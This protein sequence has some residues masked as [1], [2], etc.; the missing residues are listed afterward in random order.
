M[1]IM[2]L[3]GGP[4]LSAPSSDTQS[5]GNASSSQ[6]QSSSENFF[7]KILTAIQGGGSSEG[8]ATSSSDLALPASKS[9]DKNG[10]TDPNQLLSAMIMM[11]I[12][13][14]LH[15]NLADANCGKPDCGQGSSSMEASISVQTA[16]ISMDQTIHQ[17]D[18]SDLQIHREIQAVAVSIEMS[19]SSSNSASA[20][21]QVHDGMN[22]I[23][24]TLDDLM[25]KAE[26]E[27]EKNFASILDSHG[28]NSPLS[29]PA[30]ANTND[31]NLMRVGNLSTSSRS[32]SIEQTRSW[33]S[34]SNGTAIAVPGSQG[35]FT[36]PN[37]DASSSKESASTP[38]TE[39]TAV[40]GATEPK[41]APTETKLG[42]LGQ[43]RTD[44][45]P[46]LQMSNAVGMPKGLSEWFSTFSNS[47]QASIPE[48]NSASAMMPTNLMSN[49]GSVPNSDASLDTGEI[50]KATGKTDSPS[51]PVPESDKLNDGQG[52]NQA[53]MATSPR[54]ESFLESSSSVGRSEN[55]ASI[56]PQPELQ[57]TMVTHARI[58][59]SQGRSE[60]VMRLDP[61]DIGTVHVHLVHSA[62]RGLEA[63]FHVPDQIRHQMEAQ[64]NELKERLQEM[65][66]ETGN[67]GFSSNANQQ[68]QS[69]SNPFFEFDPV[70]ALLGK[71]NQKGNQNNTLS[72][73]R[74]SSLL[75]IT[76]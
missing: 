25:S 48:I 10:E 50:V 9:D 36:L 41:A 45:E 58:A 53:V 24:E 21:S 3:L 76:A 32:M 70:K 74:A 11:Q 31:A 59:E 73:V 26:A 42:T 19:T 63:S 69:G 16:S 64:L 4:G 15:L 44:S 39:S 68:G 12:A 51:S 67:F 13:N 28:S 34:T 29:Q 27:M 55:R 71:N 66:F 43:N 49:I 22:R 35:A 2:Q 57:T 47:S 52:N 18:G 1:D 7:S 33:Q 40:E 61:P 6:K 5:F 60:F 37:A 54:F 38:P 75:D 30:Q 65:G 8:N 62:E 14:S 46:T 56:P 20:M 72:S 23:K 17:A